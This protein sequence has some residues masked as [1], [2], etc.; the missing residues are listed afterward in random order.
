[1]R[2]K[3]DARLGMLALTD[4]AEF[5]QAR[6]AL[7]IRNGAGRDLDRDGRA[8][9]IGNVGV[10]PQFA[11]AEQPLDH[12]RLGD[13]GRDHQMPDVLALNS[14][15]P[16]QAGVH[17]D[18]LHASA[19]RDT[20]VEHIEEVVQ[21]ARFIR[22]IAGPPQQRR[23]GRGDGNKEREGKPE[24][25]DQDN[26]GDAFAD[27]G[28]GKR[29]DRRQRDRAK[30]KQPRAQPYAERSVRRA[31]PRRCLS[32]AGGSTSPSCSASVLQSAIYA[33]QCRGSVTGVGRKS[34]NLKRLKR[35]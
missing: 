11:L 15:Q 20:F 3:R 12:V 13:E 24:T 18:G 9:A 17:R 14:D 28:G 16:A 31:L 25:G 19:H 29:L 5:E 4:I 8:V 2:K 7:A 32:G 30:G 23:H 33:R 1:M 35:P 10:E 27:R 26:D 22:R 21:A 34:E 6:R